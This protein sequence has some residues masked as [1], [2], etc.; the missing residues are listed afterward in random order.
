MKKRIVA[1]LLCCVM[2]LTLSPSLIA[3]ASATDTKSNAAKVTVTP[4]KAEMPQNEKVTLRAAAGEATSFQWQIQVD[5]TLW[6]DISGETDSTIQ[7]S[8]AMLASLLNG[9]KAAL[10]CKTD[11][12]TSAA[13]TVTV[14]DPQPVVA[15]APAKAAP[16]AGTVVKEAEAI[17]EVVTPDIAA[18]PD[19]VA[20]Q[21]MIGDAVVNDANVAGDEGTDENETPDVKKTYNIIVEYVFT[22]G[23]Q[24]A[25]PWTATIEEGSSYS[26]EVISP[27]V[28]GYKPD[29]ATQKIEV[30]NIAKDEIYR[31]TY[32]PAEVTYT[33]IHKQQN[34]NDDDYTE[35]ERETKTGYT[36]SPVAADL[37][38]EY[39]GFTALL[40][41][42][43]ATIAADGSTVVEI[44]YDRNYYLM[45]FDLDGGYGV[46]PIY[47]RYGSTIEVG[48]PTKAGYVFDKWDPKLPAAMPATN[49][50]HTAVWGKAQAV[51]YTVVYWRENANDTGY[52][53]WG[54]VTG[55]ASAGTTVSGADNVPTSIT[56]ATVDGK[57]LNE[58]PFFTYNAGKTDKNVLVKGDGT[59]IVNVYYY[60][61]TYHVYFTGISGKC[62]IEAHTHGDGNCNSYLDCQQAHTHTGACYR[63]CTKLGHTHV[64]NC[65]KDKNNNVIYVVSAKYEQNIANVWP[66]A[67]KFASYKL[68]GWTVDGNGNTTLTSKRITM[69]ANLC[70]TTDNL[71]YAKAQKGGSEHTL[72]YMFESFD[73]ASGVNGDVRKKLESKYYDSDNRYYQKVN[74]SSDSSWSQKAIE[75]MKPVSN[76]VKYSGSKV[77]LYY[78]RNRYTLQYHN[79]TDGVVKTVRNIMFEQPLANYKD[80]NEA[81]LSNFIPSYPSK[82]EPDA[83]EFKGWYTTPECYEGTQYN[84]STATMPNG[85]LTLYAKWVPVTHTVKT[86]LTKDAMEN[87]EATLDSWTV[88]HGTMVEPAPDEPE[89][90]KYTFVGWFYMDDGVEKAFDFENMP[91]R[92]DLNLYAKWSSN[93][94]VNYTIKY[95]V[96]DENGN[97]TYIADDTTGSALADSTQTFE[98]KTGNQLNVGYRAG[99]FPKTNSHSMTM[100]IDGNNE[101]TFIYV[102]KEKVKYTV[103]YLVKGA[104]PKTT[105]DD[106]ILHAD[107]KGETPNAI[108]TEKFEVVKGYRPDAYQKRLVLSANESEN[109]IIFW[110][111]QDTEHAPV[112]IIH[113]KQNISGEGYSDFNRATN[114]DADINK[115]QTS[116]AM[117]ISGF[118][119]VKGT[120]VV[121]ETTKE[122]NAPKTPEAVLTAD[123]LVLN[124]YYDR[125]EYPYEFRFLE[126]GTNKVLADPVT[127]NARYQAQV[128]QTA[129][130]IPGYTLAEGIAVNQA[131]TI[132]IEDGTTADKNVKIFYYTEQTVD[133]KYVAVTP[134]RGTLSSYQDNGVKVV[135]GTVNGS[136]PTAKD[137]FRFV[138]WFKD[139]ACTVAVDESWVDASNKLTPQKTKDLGDNVKGYE[140]ATYYAKFEEALTSLTIKKDYTGGALMDPNQSAVFVVT[141]DGLGAEGLTVVLNRGNG[142]QVTINDLKVGKVYTVT[143]KDSWTWRYTRESVSTANGS[144]KLEADGKTV[145]FTNTLNNGYWLTGGTYCDNRWIDKTTVDSATKS[146]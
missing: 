41:N 37:A 127:G 68:K 39:D 47:A 129:K 42:T 139:A 83:Y 109:V 1:L 136:T 131:I 65:N 22:D 120:A 11:V 7:V 78:D 118:T 72:Y 99:Y 58:K 10:R 31:V 57:T 97:R 4:A 85:N 49:T 126:Q 101:Y 143:E 79:S 9:N 51:K 45:K 20:T 44:K 123:G 40:Y 54:Q 30:T 137:G 33:V 98:A 28:L 81:L 88:P 107:K 108:I 140:A 128:T 138:G 24:A 114:L 84:F 141:G 69:T 82:L 100:N 34:M 76:G 23:T 135:N 8:Y 38:R 105:N 35:S 70:D 133:I 103:R 67:D 14:T 104:D 50:T 77:F 13:V 106:D 46:E 144:I 63:A 90:R 145:T 5:D 16:K 52:S 102:Q 3:S 96:E 17:G 134:E 146:N 12:G 125:I 15:A 142:Y 91:V 74:S 87:N 71:K 80:D 89:N 62:V 2:L 116:E 32:S 95:A 29:K 6:V 93:V 53:F 75:G 64:N 86:W 60:R 119:Y 26:G 112:E 48:T 92:K 124:L 122:F 27:D 21:E 61:N 130:T 18:T 19:A 59:S 56:N 115:K 94:M 66:T 121:G 73:Q 132:D 113:W 110:Y 25:N 36:E 111:V 43:N 117:D 55:Q